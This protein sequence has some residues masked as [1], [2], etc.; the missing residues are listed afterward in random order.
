MKSEVRGQ[1]SLEFLTVTGIGLLVI[2]AAAI[3]FLSYAQTSGDDARLAQV[4]DIGISII[5]QAN[6]WYSVGGYSWGT[7]D[8]VMPDNV[9]DVYTVENN[10]LV[11]D[12]E[13]RYGIV[14]QPVFSTTP[15]IGYTTTGNISSIY[16]PA[17]GPHSGASKL[18][19]T[20]LGS[21]VQIQAVG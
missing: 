7:V 6:Y 2:S 20:S 16:S 13:T 14:R 21:I 18:R 4:T 19:V 15:I 8:V 9:I 10:T 17:I 1:S 11:F 3:A 5:G 12:V